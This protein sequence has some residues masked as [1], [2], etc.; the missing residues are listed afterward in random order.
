MDVMCYRSG[1][2]PD[3]KG[4]DWLKVIDHLEGSIYTIL[5]RFGNNY[6]GYLSGKN[7][8]R[9]TVYPLYK[10]NRIDAPRP[11]YYKEIRQYLIDEWGAIV[12]DGAEADD[13]LGLAHNDDTVICSI[14]KDLRSLPGYFYNL[15]TN[16]LEYIDKEQAIQ[17]F[18]VQ[19]LTG[20]KSDNVPGLPNPLKSHHKNPPNFTENSARSY[21]NNKTIQE[22][23]SL[24]QELYHDSDNFNM[25]ATLLWIQRKDA[26]TY[27][28]CNL[29][30]QDTLKAV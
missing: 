28:D 12:V 3:T 18:L 26:L 7:N 5:D 10:A 13:A 16:Q 23:F 15:N 1:F 29:L 9:R 22:Q 17:N 4:K 27:K 14:D 25:I 11:K 24:I 6:K 19:L 8:F 30:N 2:E 20:D 21:L